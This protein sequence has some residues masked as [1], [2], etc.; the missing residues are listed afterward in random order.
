MNMTRGKGRGPETELPAIE[1]LGDAAASSAEGEACSEAL[2][3]TDTRK[4]ILDC[5]RAAER[6]LKDSAE[7]MRGQD[8]QSFF[9][10]EVPQSRQSRCRLKG[11]GEVSVSVS[12]VRDGRRN[13]TG[14]VYRLHS[15]E[16]SPRAIVGA[17]EGGLSD[18][19]LEGITREQT[20]AAIGEVTSKIAHD[21]SG[22]LTAITG[23]AQVIMET[24]EDPEIREGLGVIQNESR[25]IYAMVQDISSLI[26]ERRAEKRARVSL[27]ACV[28]SALELHRWRL[29]EKNIRVQTDLAPDLPDVLAD[30]RKMEIVFW[31]LIRNAEEAMGDGGRLAIQSRAS[32]GYV[33]VSV[34][35]S[36]PG[37]SEEVRGSLFEPFF[38]TKGVE[39]GVGLGLAIC[40]RI[41]RGH[42]GRIYAESNNGAG[43]VMTVQLPVLPS[44]DE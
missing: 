19:I 18:G 6:L 9:K 25:R 4:R 11:G 36:G 21:V 34:A 22:P 31:N 3:W 7:G 29:E 5:N 42:G 41:V 17:N 35:D 40:R 12:V 20:L 27:N 28:G 24:V 10:G 1:S 13:P 33:S 37:I 32:D 23:Y 39:G 26:R 14:F 30:A 16:G 15:V 43:T 38:T 8:I 44:E 2:V